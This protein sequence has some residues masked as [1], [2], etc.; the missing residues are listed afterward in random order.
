MAPKIKRSD[1]GALAFW[2]AI[3]R[4][5][6]RS[7]SL[8]AVSPTPLARA[9]DSR[10]RRG[11]APG[12]V[13]VLLDASGI[14]STAAAIQRRPG[15]PKIKRGCERA[16]HMPARHVGARP[17]ARREAELLRCAQDQTLRRWRARDLHGR[18]ATIC[19]LRNLNA[20]RAD[21]ASSRQW[22]AAAPRLRARRGVR[23]PRRERNREH[24]GGDP[25]AA[26]RCAQNQNAGAS[27][28]FT[29]RRGTWSKASGSTRGGAAQVRPKSSAQ[30]LA[31]SRS[32]RPSRDDLRSPKIKCRPRRRR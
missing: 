14:A 8:S 25:A 18:R 3:A 16:L 26:A 12:A 19:D 17:R 15:A 32:A 4:D 31:R 20:A 10:P 1:A 24:R 6:L 21:A 5:D 9:S 28:L 11:Y 7:S 2:T 23:P 30:T 13:C 29:C 22:L 27:V